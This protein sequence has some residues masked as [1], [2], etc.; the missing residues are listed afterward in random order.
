M[1]I[2]PEKIR[3]VEASGWF[4]WLHCHF[5][6]RY[7][8]EVVPNVEETGI[9]W[10]AVKLS[11]DLGDWQSWINPH[12]WTIGASGNRLLLE[13]IWDDLTPLQRGTALAGFSEGHKPKDWIAPGLSKC[14]FDALTTSELV[15]NALLHRRSD[16]I[17]DILRLSTDLSGSVIRYASPS[18]REIGA[19]DTAGKL[20]R[21]C[22]DMILEAALIQENLAT[23]RLALDHGADPNIPIWVADRTYTDF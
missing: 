11:D 21:R 12:L 1:K 2:D 19:S 6:S 18:R 7:P 22:I 23:V 5:Y 20:S 14:S 13:A 3:P 10:A 16:I 9:D 15:C 17:P 8:R 4:R